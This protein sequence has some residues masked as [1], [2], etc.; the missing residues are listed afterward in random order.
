MVSF[1]LQGLSAPLYGA[2]AENAIMFLA[3][4]ETKRLLGRP[5]EQLP[6]HYTA[7]AGFVSG[8]TVAFWLTPVVRFLTYPPSTRSFHCARIISSHRILL[9]F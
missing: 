6:L 9:F 3:Y 2:M 7:L 8:C 5:N 1:L 4:G